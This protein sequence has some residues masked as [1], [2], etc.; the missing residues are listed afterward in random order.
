MERAEAVVLTAAG[1]AAPAPLWPRPG[2]LP[3]PSPGGSAVEG[4]VAATSALIAVQMAS[5][6]GK[7]A[8][9]AELQ[10]LRDE[11]CSAREEL[12]TMRQRLGAA[13]GR[14]DII[15][16]FGIPSKQQMPSY[17]NL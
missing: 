10:R 12:G 3:P 4:L 17:N 15:L 2:T 9:I 16:S 7:G 14:P 11:V 13:H 6:V 8:D 1:G 5:P